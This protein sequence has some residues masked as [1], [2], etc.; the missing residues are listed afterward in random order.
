MLMAEVECHLLQSENFVRCL[1]LPSAK[2]IYMSQ[3]PGNKPTRNHN[4]HIEHLGILSVFALSKNDITHTH[5]TR[6]PVI[7]H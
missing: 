7:T 4:H 6:I 1:Y 3:M 2:K 5:R